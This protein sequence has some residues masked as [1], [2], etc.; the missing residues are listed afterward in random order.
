MWR[1]TWNF[2]PFVRDAK[3]ILNNQN[4]KTFYTE[5]TSWSISLKPSPSDFEMMLNLPELSKPWRVDRKRFMNLK[6]CIAVW[7][8]S[9]NFSLSF[10]RYQTDGRKVGLCRASYFILVF[11]IANMCFI[12]CILIPASLLPFR[13]TQNAFSIYKSS[14]MWVERMKRAE[15][16][17][18]LELPSRSHRD[19][20][21][22]FIFL[23]LRSLHTFLA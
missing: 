1:K 22:K 11:L 23:G 5:G 12:L 7:H 16:W 9:K 2:G 18:L 6:L 8:L 15:I 10:V 21:S 4:I 14:I 17:F 19:H 13:L 20:G 3:L